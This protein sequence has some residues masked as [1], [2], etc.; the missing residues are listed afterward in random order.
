MVQPSSLISSGMKMSEFGN[1]Y[2]FRFTDELQSRFEELLDKKKADTLTLEEEAEYIGIS[3]LQRIF[4]LINAQ[5][6]AKSK[7]TFC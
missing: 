3:E 6:A 4:T 1:I 2:L 7:T 5:I